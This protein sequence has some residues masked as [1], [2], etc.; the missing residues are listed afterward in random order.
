M[1]GISSPVWISAVAAWRAHLGERARKADLGGTDA[2]LGSRFDAVR[3][4]AVDLRAPEPGGAVAVASV[5]IRSA[6]LAR[7]V[8]GVDALSTGE[9]S[10]DGDLHSLRGSRHMTT[11]LLRCLRDAL[12][13]RA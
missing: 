7:A 3:I 4:R 6:A 2:E 11:K 8:D 10:Q 1:N 13:V 9:L 5:G 12:I